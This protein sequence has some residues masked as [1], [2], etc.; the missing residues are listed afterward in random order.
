M[1]RPWGS[2]VAEVVLDGLGALRMHDQASDAFRRRKGG[3]MTNRRAFLGLTGFG[4]GAFIVPGVAY[5]AGDCAGPSDVAV[6]RALLDRYVA[7]VNA[8]DTSSFAE[9]FA[10]TYLQRSGRSPSGLAAQIENAQ[11]FF[12]A[13]PGLHLAVEDSIFAFDKI[14]ARCTYSGTQRGKFAGVEPTGKRI[15]FGTIDIWRVEGGKLAEHWDQ[16]DFAG[17]L[18][19]LR[20]S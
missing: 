7:A 5:A 4:A 9:I 11:R 17:I 19:Q 8:H 13:L 20:D 16:V 14:V 1:R 2:V 15:V 12:T 10:E 3:I 6:N 18:K